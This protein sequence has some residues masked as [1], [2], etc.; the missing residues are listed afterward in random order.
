MS[1]HAITAPLRNAVH[2]VPP[3]AVVRHARPDVPMPRHA[4]T[5]K[6]NVAHYTIDFANAGKQQ[7]RTACKNAALRKR[8]PPAG[9][10]K[11]RAFALLDVKPAARCAQDMLY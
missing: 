11:P 6:I 4:A 10:V 2:V 9:R 3:T 8:M 7:C 1:C 5:N